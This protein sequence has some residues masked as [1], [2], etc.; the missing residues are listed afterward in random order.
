MDSWYHPNLEGAELFLLSDTGYSNTQLALDWL[1]HFIE[2]TAPYKQEEPKVLLLDSHTS[3][4]SSKFLTAAEA[5]YIQPYTFPSHLIHI[6][7]PL[8]VG[9]FQPYKHYYREAVLTAIRDMDLEY[10]VASFIRDLPNIRKQTFEE[11]TIISAVIELRLC[12]YGF[13]I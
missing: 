6:L 4:L 8:D 11:S 10:N 5:S 2:H 9:I 3:Y 12:R 1:Q 7:Q 13:L